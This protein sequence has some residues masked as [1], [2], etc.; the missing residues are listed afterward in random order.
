[1]PMRQRLH[2]AQPAWISTVTRSPMANSST[3]GPSAAMVPMYSWPGVQFLLNGKPPCT[4]AGGPV[5]ITSRSVA[6]IA[7]ASMR[8]NTSA[9]RGTGTGFSMSASSPG[10]PNTQ[11]RIVAGT[12]NLASVFTPGGA[13]IGNLL[14][15]TPIDRFASGN[16]LGAHSVRHR[17]RRVGAGKEL[18]RGKDEIG[19][20]D[21]L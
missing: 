9:A 10:S 14:I 18:H 20:A 3:P 19:V 2:C 17:Q 12:A 16:G 5:A 13:Y 15:T 8:T 1:M 7:T 11:A 6:Q 21:V 4:S